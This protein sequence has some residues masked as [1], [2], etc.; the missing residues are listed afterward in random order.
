MKSL[1]I[2][3]KFVFVVGLAFVQLVAFGQ[4][5]DL[6]NGEY[7]ALLERSDGNDIVFNFLVIDRKIG[8]KRLFIQNAGELI[9]VDNISQSGDSI[10]IEMPFFEAQL[11]LRR[12]APGQLSGYYY[13]HLQNS[14]QVIPMEANQ[15]TVKHGEAN[16][17]EYMRFP[18]ASVAAPSKVAGRWAVTFRDDSTGVTTADVG[19]F[20]QHGNKVTGTFLDPTGDY[21]YL[22]GVVDGDSLKLSCFDGSHAY[23]FTAR[24]KGDKMTGRHY[25]GPTFK[26]SWTARRD[27]QA[28]LADEFTLT[29]MRP[30]NSSLHFRFRDLNGKFV[31][32]K[33]KRY[34]NKVVVVQLMGSWCPNC[35]DETAVLAKMYDH[36][37][38]KGLEVIGLAYE[39]STNFE[40][41][42]TSLENFHKHLG[43]HYE[44]LITGVSVYDS[45]KT[46][47]TLP[48]LSN[49]EGFPTTIFLGKDHQVE[50]IHTGFN[51][52]G[53]G[54][55]YEE[56]KKEFYNIVDGLLAQ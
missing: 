39:R 52:P 35:M 14:Y 45:L 40:R 37:H 30:G 33:A 3:T 25:A 42:R 48:E 1:S 43:V 7:R 38:R 16:R 26:N 28:K 10:I 27:E 49:I 36:Y 8:N 13:K 34:Q 18:L 12:A 19:E 47:K 6:G 29:K 5:I 41:S 56:Q 21:R 20:V 50:R 32:L 46:Q 11:H 4:K 24:I 54:E 2:L 23:L 15:L 53:T 51:G 22:E 55:H 44:M 9:Q 31:S 17:N